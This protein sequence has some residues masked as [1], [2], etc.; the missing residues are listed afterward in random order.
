MPM[1][2]A[3]AE[4][5][6]EA[7]AHNV[8]VLRRSSGGAALW[9]VVKADGYG[10]GAV[11][12]ARAA[13]AAGVDGLCV[14]LVQ[15][16]RALRAA[17]VDA[18]ILV[19]SEQPAEQAG[20]A[21]AA[22]VVSTVVSAAGVSAVERAAA[23]AGVRHAVHLKVDTG[24]HRMGCAPEEAVDL[25]RQVVASESLRL[26][27][28]FT[29]LATADQPGH[30][31]VGLQVDRFDAVLEQLRAAGVDPGVVHLANSAA[32]LAIPGAGRDAVRVGI[33]LYGLSPGPGVDAMAT[34]LRPVMSLH[35]RVSRV[36]RAAAGDGVSYGWTHVLRRPTTLA[37]V[38]IGYADGVP[39]RLS[40]VGGEV[41][42][43]GVRRPIVGVVTMDQLVVD[44]GDLTVRVGDPVVL[45]GRQG[46]D[47]ITATE[48]ADRLGTIGYEIVCGVSA[49]VPRVT[50][51]VDSTA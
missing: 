15:E 12:V 40:A 5:D 33:A 43:G 27:G 24:M 10:H 17:D 38:P 45:I 21:V 6:L 25:A 9:A 2:W 31:A 20:D 49:R 26:D 1:R 8:E 48:W 4:I 3:W 11:T 23:S 29:H 7:L 22:G 42:V 46:G 37:T 50:G 51:V 34:D 36:Q 28:V 41:L 13:L 16:A 19:L 35:A 30:A 14:A 44:V 47:E 18:S 39:R 32:T